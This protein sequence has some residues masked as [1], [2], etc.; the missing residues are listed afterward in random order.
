MQTCQRRSSAGTAPKVAGL[1]AFYSVA[2]SFQE[3]MP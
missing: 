3:N 2:M 1:Q